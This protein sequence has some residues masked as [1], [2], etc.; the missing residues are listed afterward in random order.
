VDGRS[1]IF[2]LGAVLYELLSGR[3]AFRR[4][5]MV[6]TLAA[7]MMTEQAPL[8]DAPAAAGRVVRKMLEKKREDRYQSAEELLVGLRAAAT[9][10]AQARRRL[11]LALAASIV[12]L[13]ALAVGFDVRGLRTRLVAW[14]QVP[15]PSIR[16]AVLPFAN[17]SGDPEQEYLSDGITQEM[18]TQL[19]KL[20]PGTLSVIARTSVMRYKQATPPIDQVGRELN[21]D[22]VLEGSARREGGRVRI[23]AELITVRGQAQMWADSYER[24]VA[25]ILAVQSEVAQQ[26]ARS[27][28]LRL[29]PA[30]QARLANVRQVNPEAYDAYLKGLHHWYKVTP[31]ELD[32]AE[33]YYKLALTKDP[34]YAAAYAGIAGVWAGRQQMGYTPVAEA[35][36]KARA[37]ARKAVELNPDDSSAHHALAI[38]LAWSD[39]EWNAAEKEFRRALELDP[40]SPDVHAYYSHLLAHLGRTT[41]ALAQMERALELDPLNPLLHA[42]YGV[43]LNYARRYDDAV[44]QFRK[45]LQA[46]PGHPIAQAVIADSFFMKGTYQEAAA[47]MRTYLTNTYPG[48]ALGQLPGQIGSRREYASVM[49][50]FGDVLLS[51]SRKAYVL[52]SDVVVVSAHA[53][54]KLRTLEWLEKGV[55]LRDPNM[56]YIGVPSNDSLRSEPRFQAVMR[57]MNLAP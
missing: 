38:T 52:P 27:L 40:N 36:P 2:S 16:L 34:N 18:I 35:A 12:L 14:M 6:A 57:R 23:T 17:L 46:E 20:H 4:E 29:L 42:L 41:E 30:E 44:A 3:K 32:S 13:L 22:Y 19:G 15:T 26:V 39:W 21:V 5:G 51:Y 11:V 43:V 45:T 37:A 50:Q 47:A 49:K 54:D 9:G 56:P 25:G 55:E 8:K 28:T 10:A 53:G 7:V 31:G 24:E 33:Q 1:D 48:I